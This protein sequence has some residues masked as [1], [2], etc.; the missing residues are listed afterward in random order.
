MKPFSSIGVVKV[1]WILLGLLAISAALISLGTTDMS[2]SPSA[3]SY[4]PSGTAALAE[5]LTQSGYQ[6]RIS[7][8]VRPNLQPGDLA[9]CFLV[10]PGASESFRQKS[11]H[12][13]EIQTQAAVASFLRQGGAALVLDLPHNFQD[14]AQL[15]QPFKDFLGQSGHT[16]SRTSQAGVPEFAQ[17]D[18]VQHIPL[19]KRADVDSIAT[20]SKVGQGYMLSMFDGLLG[21]NR[22]IDQADNAAVLLKAVSFLAKPGARVEFVEGTWGNA[23]PPGVMEAIGP[24]A[25]GA[26]RQLLFLGIIVIFTLGRRFG[27][28]LVTHSQEHSSKELVDA[29]ANVYQR[30][31]SGAVAL[32]VAIERVETLLRRRLKLTREITGRDLAVRLPDPL[33]TTLLQAARLANENCDSVTA[34][35]TAQR[36]DREAGD[37]LQ[38]SRAAATI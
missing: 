14:S 2:S 4:T 23:T 38:D 21:T 25:L 1:A 22:Y 9:I 11:K 33:S 5:L 30:S 10:E 32:K 36:L 37:Y 3:T 31:G 12:D 27:V 28:G 35:E 26:W 34:I 17:N 8:S 18:D 15:D 6:V 16:V 7:N 29:L 20:L 24:W 13:P 19:G